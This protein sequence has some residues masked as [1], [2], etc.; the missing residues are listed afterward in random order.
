M[1]RAWRPAQPALDASPRS[2]RTNSGEAIAGS[3]ASA[4]SSKRPS[5]WKAKPSTFTGGVSLVNCAMLKSRSKRPSTLPAHSHASLAHRGNGRQPVPPLPQRA[6]ALVGQA[7]HVR[8]AVVLRLLARQEAFGDQSFGK[9]GH[10]AVRH[11]HAARQLAKQ[12]PVLHALQLRRHAR[13]RRRDRG[14]PAVGQRSDPARRIRSRWLHL[15]GRR[16]ERQLVGQPDEDLMEAPEGD[17]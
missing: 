17:F 10:I 12:Q 8:A 11:H 1:L 9:A 3:S 13:V 16:R 7:H 14:D 5:A 15:V 2:S 6:A 4:T